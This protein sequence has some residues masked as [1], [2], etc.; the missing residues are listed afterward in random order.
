MIKLVD[1][2]R[3]IYKYVN[4][5]FLNVVM[6]MDS[7]EGTNVANSQPAMVNNKT[8]QSPSHEHKQ[9]EEEESTMTEAKS[10]TIMPTGTQ[11]RF[12]ESAPVESQLNH[13]TTQTRD[14]LNDLALNY[15][16][17][18]DDSGLHTLI[19]GVTG[20]GVISS[21]SSENAKST[22][23]QQQQQPHHH[24]HRQYDFN[25]YDLVSSKTLRNPYSHSTRSDSLDFDSRLGKDVIQAVADG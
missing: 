15:Q 21:T 2:S 24:L 9:R 1:T 5:Y 13:L 8:E 17:L 14:D 18:A 19:R 7:L 4:A 6:F 16:N 11:Q 10:S 23:R 3:L 22:L 12:N 20:S 25:Y